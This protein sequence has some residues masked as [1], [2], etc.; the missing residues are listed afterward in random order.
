MHTL[1]YSSKNSLELWT[2]NLP[3]P[4]SLFCGSMFSVFFPK[5]AG[6]DREQAFSALEI[7]V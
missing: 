1:I 5:N 6:V 2:L 4:F 7:V 3:D